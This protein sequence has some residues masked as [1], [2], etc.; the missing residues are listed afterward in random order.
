MFAVVFQVRALRWSIAREGPAWYRV[1][2]LKAE[3]MRTSLLAFL[4]LNFTA[5][6]LLAQAPLP[7]V[8]SVGQPAD[9]PFLAPPAVDVPTTVGAPISRSADTTPKR[10]NDSLAPPTIDVPNL[11]GAPLPPPAAAG[12]EP[13]QRPRF[14]RLPQPQPGTAAQAA[15]APGAGANQQGKLGSRWKQRN[16]PPL[17]DAPLAGSSANLESQHAAPEPDSKPTKRSTNPRKYGPVELFPKAKESD[18]A[19]NPF[20]IRRP[21]LAW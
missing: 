1:K 12:N 16:A 13:K 2:F 7:P 15:A 20:S 19:G 4:L 18:R 10:A 11:G 3:P 5:S 17:T 14:F 8:V 21:I 6:G 9:G